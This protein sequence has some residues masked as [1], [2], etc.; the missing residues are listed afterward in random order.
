MS[1]NVLGYC[2]KST[3]ASLKKHSLL[4]IS[5]NEANENRGKFSGK[6]NKNEW[7]KRINKKKGIEKFVCKAIESIIAPIEENR[8]D[9]Y[10]TRNPDNG[11]GYFVI[12]IK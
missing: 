8:K 3:T 1:F 11:S 5:I 10:K 7:R 6:S 2:R 4:R 12:L 9:A